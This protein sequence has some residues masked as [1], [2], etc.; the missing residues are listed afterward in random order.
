MD[1]IDQLLEVSNQVP[2][3]IRIHSLDKDE[4]MRL[5][6]LPGGK[7]VETFMDGSKQKELNYEF[8]YK[9]KCENA[10][11]IMIELGE[12][13]EEQEDI[14]SS[15][16]SYQFVGITIVDE[17]FFTGYDDKQFLYYRLAIKATLYFDK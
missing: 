3:P 12:L 7:T 16:N 1:F 5:T 15:N 13:L 8:V 17:P 10:D 6:A 2:V 9:T 11:R 14:P 4:S